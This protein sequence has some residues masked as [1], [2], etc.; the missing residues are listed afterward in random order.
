MENSSKPETN[1]EPL[2]KF[3]TEDITPA[4]FSIL[5]DEF[6]YDYITMLVRIQL[7]DDEDKIIH[8]NTDQFIFYIRHLREALALC[9]NCQM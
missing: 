4:E 9:G 7:S 3:F 2:H 8:T 6:L 5:L 1:L